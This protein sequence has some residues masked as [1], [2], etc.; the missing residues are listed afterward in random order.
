MTNHP[1]AAGVVELAMLVRDELQ[2]T[3]VGVALLGAARDT[4]L[5]SAAAAKDQGARSFAFAVQTLL[6]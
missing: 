1:S 2:Y 3:T 5:G 6:K 4:G